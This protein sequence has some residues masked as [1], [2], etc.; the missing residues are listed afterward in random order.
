MT[1]ELNHKVSLFPQWLLYALSAA[2]MTAFFAKFGRVICCCYWPLEWCGG[3]V[4]RRWNGLRRILCPCMNPYRWLTITI[5]RAVVR[6]SMHSV[7]S[8]GKFVPRDLQVGV[9]FGQIWPLGAYEMWKTAESGMMTQPVQVEAQQLGGGAV[10]L[11]T[12]CADLPAGRTIFQKVDLDGE[13]AG[14]EQWITRRCFRSAGDIQVMS[15]WRVEEISSLNLGQWT[16]R[17]SGDQMSGHHDPNEVLSEIRRLTGHEEVMQ[18]EL[19]GIQPGAAEWP[20]IQRQQDTGRVGEDAMSLMYVGSEEDLILVLHVFIEKEVLEKEAQAKQRRLQSPYQG[21]LQRFVQAEKEQVSALLDNVDDAAD[22]AQEEIRHALSRKRMLRSL[23]PEEED[24][25]QLHRAVIVEVRPSDL[26]AGPRQN[27]F[28]GSKHLL[29]VYTE[30]AAS[31]VARATLVSLRR[32]RVEVAPGRGPLRGQVKLCGFLVPR[33]ALQQVQHPQRM[34]PNS[35]TTRVDAFSGARFK[36]ALE[37]TFPLRP[38]DVEAHLMMRPKASFAERLSGAI[39]HIPLAGTKLSSMFLWVTGAG[40]HDDGLFKGDIRLEIRPDIEGGSVTCSVAGGAAIRISDAHLQGLGSRRQ[41]MEL[42][43]PGL[44]H[45]RCSYLLEFRMRCSTVSSTTSFPNTP[46]PHITFGWCMFVVSLPQI[47]VGLWEIIAAGCILIRLDKVPDKQEDDLCERTVRFKRGGFLT[48]MGIAF[49]GLALCMCSLKRYRKSTTLMFLCSLVVLSVCTPTMILGQRV[50]IYF[51][52][53]R[54]SNAGLTS[55]LARYL[56][57]LSPIA[58]ILTVLDFIPVVVLISNLPTL[59]NYF[60]YGN[61]LPTRLANGQ[62]SPFVLELPARAARMVGLIEPALAVLT[63]IKASANSASRGAGSEEKSTLLELIVCDQGSWMDMSSTHYFSEVVQTVVET[64]SPDDFISLPAFQ[65]AI[66]ALYG[67]G[68]AVNPSLFTSKLLFW[69]FCDVAT[70]GLGVGEDDDV[71]SEERLSLGAFTA[72]WQAEVPELEGFKRALRDSFQTEASSALSAQLAWQKLKATGAVQELVSRWQRSTPAN[73]RTN[74]RLNV[75]LKGNPKILRAATLHVAILVRYLGRLKR[76][77]LHGKVACSELECEPR[78]VALK[79]HDAHFSCFD[80]YCIGFQLRPLE[81]QAVEGTSE[82][83]PV[84]PKKWA[85]LLKEYTSSIQVGWELLQGDVPLE[86]GIDHPLDFTLEEAANFD[87]AED[88][89]VVGTAARIERLQWH[90]WDTLP[91]DDTNDSPNSRLASLL[92]SGE[93][94]G[95]AGQHV[96]AIVMSW[97][98]ISSRYLLL[99]WLREKY[100]RNPASSNM[101]VDI[102]AVLQEFSQNLGDNLNGTP[103]RSI[104][105]GFDVRRKVSFCTPAQALLQESGGGVPVFRRIFD[106]DFGFKARGVLG[107]KLSSKPNVAPIAP[108]WELTSIQQCLGKENSDRE[109]PWE[110]ADGGD[111]LLWLQKDNVKNGEVELLGL[112]RI[113]M[114]VNGTVHEVAHDCGPLL[115]GAEVAQLEEEEGMTGMELSRMLRDIKEQQAKAKASNSVHKLNVQL[116]MLADVVSLRSAVDKEASKRPREIL[117]LSE[118]GAVVPFGAQFVSSKSELVHVQCSDLAKL[119]EMLSTKEGQELLPAVAVVQFPNSR[120][121]D[122]PGD[123][124]MMVLHFMVLAKVNRFAPSKTDCQKAL[125]KIT[126]GSSVADQFQALT[127][128]AQGRSWP[129]QLGC[130]GKHGRRHAG[131][132]SKDHAL[133]PMQ[134]IKGE[135]EWKD[136]LQHTVACSICCQFLND[137]HEKYHCKPCNVYLCSDCASRVDEL[138]EELRYSS[139]LAQEQVDSGAGLDI[140]LLIKSA[141]NKTDLP[142]PPGAEQSLVESVKKGGDTLEECLKGLM[143]LADPLVCP[144]CDD[145]LAQFSWR[146]RTLKTRICRT[147][148]KKIASNEHQYGCRKCSNHICLECGQQA[149]KHQS[150]LAPAT[151]ARRGAVV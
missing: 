41:V 10:F 51:E 79:D 20:N 138:K 26:D 72:Q 63:P 81:S 137:G 43:S 58:L 29:H 120:L 9:S 129:L 133:Y 110:K 4:A 136:V 24:R 50:K 17:F 151:E 54:T 80:E 117:E 97:W 35:E 95:A 141:F 112:R 74:L 118:L 47:I 145:P 150:R 115:L 45:V 76:G 143:P 82:V 15:G 61:T 128:L 113:Y 124:E 101:A 123:I 23:L 55:L 56:S 85:K 42:H 135:T 108:G 107:T 49:I 96:G 89:A 2:G 142:L 121:L 19:A 75:S 64:S 13:A 146:P 92:S 62:D 57:M 48:A 111:P 78:Q 69:A 66:Q 1:M 134:Y 125:K 88:A 116:K 3:A 30:T 8:V 5:D 73:D 144:A 33:A 149:R 131:S 139:Q 59:W 18:V 52:R 32:C 7:G 130:I 6:Q 11:R 105:L 126:K 148:K 109:Q 114:D 86:A 127:C 31:R 102:S 68:V 22:E 122:V 106:D 100:E 65:S 28:L 119:E 39:S 14:K 103:G 94:A 84:D 98:P 53:H 70:P 83:D 87:D 40:T 12:R 21:T 90:L 91:G 67:N 77:C 147:C 37:F 60:F 71:W 25:F 16:K 46:Q 34:D 44:P 132:Q 99:K 36:H 93:S 38:G 27:A 104:T 140:S